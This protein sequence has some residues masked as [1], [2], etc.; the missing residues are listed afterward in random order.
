[1][2]VNPRAEHFGAREIDLRDVTFTR[3]LL[4]LIPAEFA[5]RHLIL[6]VLDSPHRVVV[7]MADPSDIGAID[8]LQGRL[9][10]EVEICVADESQVQE[11]IGRLYG[12]E[13]AP[14]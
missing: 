6:P 5:R 7:G 12:S 13:G 10:R 14:A 1:M 3:D 9:Q 8:E 2:A 11:F 4:A